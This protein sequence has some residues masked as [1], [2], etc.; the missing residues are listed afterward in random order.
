MMVGDSQTSKTL[1]LNIVELIIGRH[2]VTQLRT[3]MLK[4]RFEIGRYEGKTFLGAKDVAGNFLQ[5]SSAPIIISRR[6]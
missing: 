6:P 1:L 3:W 2:N 5:H 4:E